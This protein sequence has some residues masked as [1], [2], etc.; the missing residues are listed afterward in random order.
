[1]HVVM[2]KKPGPDA[3]KSDEGKRAEDVVAF[4][5]LGVSPGKGAAAPVIGPVSKALSFTRDPR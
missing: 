4:H 5:G 3:E 1:M 2:K